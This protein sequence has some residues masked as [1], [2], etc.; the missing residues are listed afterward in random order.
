MK[1]PEFPINTFS[2]AAELL[3]EHNIW[4]IQLSRQ[5]SKDLQAVIERTAG[6]LAD[7]GLNPDRKF[8]VE[9]INRIKTALDWAVGGG[10]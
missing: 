7:I 5:E 3:T 6:L 9:D 10:A 1:R 2:Y 8:S 4:D